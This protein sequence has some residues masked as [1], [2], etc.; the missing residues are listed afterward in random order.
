MVRHQERKT[1]LVKQD[2]EK[3]KQTRLDGKVRDILRPPHITISCMIIGVAL[4]Y[5]SVDPD[6]SL[7]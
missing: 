5:L 3:P 1:L 4:K 6:L 7:F 2:R